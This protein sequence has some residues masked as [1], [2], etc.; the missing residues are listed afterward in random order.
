MRIKIQVR[1]NN[2]EAY[3]NPDALQ[4]GSRRSAIGEELKTDALLH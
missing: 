2:G 3:L 4:S 1:E